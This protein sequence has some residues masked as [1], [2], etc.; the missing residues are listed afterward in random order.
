MTKEI[1]KREQ[2]LELHN[3]ILVSAQLAQ[4]NL[5]EM[6]SGLKQMRDGKLYKELGYQNFEEYCNEEF[7]MSRRNAYHYI[8]VVE[9][10]SPENVKTF[11]HF[12]R[13]KLMLLSTLSEPEQEKITEENDV[14][15]MTVRELEKEIRELKEKNSALKLDLDELAE[16]H[17]RTC[18]KA[19]EDVNK[20]RSGLRI[21]EAQN[22]ELRDQIKELEARPIEVAVAEP[23]EDVRRLKETIKSL[24]RSTEEQIE[25]MEN[26]HIEDVRKIHRQHSEELKEALNAQEREFEEITH[27]LEERNRELEGRLDALENGET[28]DSTLELLDVY[29]N[30]AH[31]ALFN[32]LAFASKAMDRSACFARIKTLLV[33]FENLN[34]ELIYGRQS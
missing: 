28:E 16:E 11:S 34:D 32:L 21:A 10:I 29:Y 7:N 6:C 3:K 15:S 18:E 14:E 22:D 5:W 8:S 25:R 2:A 4:N 20:Y 24:E 13:S 19:K 17:E 27:E 23:S 12:G 1:T 9:N 33:E 26:E 31:D 30:T